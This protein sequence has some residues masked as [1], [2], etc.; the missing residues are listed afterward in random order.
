MV[1]LMVLKRDD[2]TADRLVGALDSMM[3]I[4]LAAP[5]VGKLDIRWDTEMVEHWEFYL[6]VT[7][8]VMM[9]FLMVDQKV[10]L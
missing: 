9:V 3:G 7:M 2:A 8:A 4:Y 5:M 10:H 1:L 6:A